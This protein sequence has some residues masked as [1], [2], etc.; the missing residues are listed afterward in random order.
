MQSTRRPERAKA[1]NPLAIYKAVALTGRIAYC[2][3]TQGVALGY[4]LLP[5]Q[6]VLL[7]G[8]LPFQGVLLIGALPFIPF[9][10]RYSIPFGR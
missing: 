9:D 4:E 7:I 10:K 2:L 8:A 1:F 5:F 6:G 3:Y